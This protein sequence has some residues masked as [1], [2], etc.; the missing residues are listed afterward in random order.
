MSNDC[1]CHGAHGAQ[2]QKAA[3]LLEQPRYWPGL[4]LQD[5][6]LT[7]AVDYT[8][9]L[10]RLLVRNL[11]G[12]G[13]VCGLTVT[14]KDHCG[15]KVEVSPG[16]ALDGCGDPVQLTK[17]LTFSWNEHETEK[18]IKGGPFWLVLCGK[19]KYCAPRSLVC[20]ADEF[21]AISRNTRAR[22]VAE[23][24]VIFEK[25]ECSCM[26][27][28]ADT[29]TAQT[30][31]APDKIIETTKAYP[32]DCAEDCGCGSACDCGCC[33]VLAEISYN[34]GWIVTH[35]DVRRI[36][37][38]IMMPDIEPVTKPVRTVTMPP[39]PTTPAPV[40]VPDP[41]EEQVKVPGVKEVKKQNTVI[42][43]KLLA[44]AQKRLEL[45]K[46]KAPSTTKAER[47]ELAAEVQSIKEQIEDLQKLL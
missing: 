24:S 36:V 13:V 33:V 8:R 17:P 44:D 21:D 3:G 2:T 47:D 26:A 31:G 6:D 16:L 19:E 12:C 42:I 28:I 32:F 18:L 37:R 35:K 45:L 39:P 38:P 43:E 46:K 41:P 22:A 27:V 5:S 29:A 1:N 14:A 15:L 40:R 34:E 9:D 25:P 20:E 11:F 7:S 4:T 10:S 30:V 23:V